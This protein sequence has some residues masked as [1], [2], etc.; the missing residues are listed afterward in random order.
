MPEFPSFLPPRS[1]ETMK[2]P[3]V[4]RM[5]VLAWLLINCTA[6]AQQRTSASTQ[7]ATGKTSGLPDEDKLRMRLQFHPH[8][9][10]AHKELIRLLQKKYA[11]RA[12]VAEDTTWLSNNRSDSWALTEIVSYSESALHDPEYAIAQLR[13]QLS[14]VPRKDDPEDFD[15]WSDQLA[16]KLQKRGRSDEALP[17]LGRITGHVRNASNSPSCSGRVT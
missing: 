17:L 10:D 2:A 7:H 12:V 15:N 13:L 5:V 4:V 8:D 1:K 9:A 11:F 3:L 14:A 6:S 16:G